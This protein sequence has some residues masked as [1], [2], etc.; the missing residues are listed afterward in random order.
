MKRRVPGPGATVDALDGGPSSGITSDNRVACKRR[1][2][3]LERIMRALCGKTV[4]EITFEGPCGKTSAAG[5]CGMYPSP[6]V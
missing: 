3:E 5:S 1:S 4:R 6:S 2:A